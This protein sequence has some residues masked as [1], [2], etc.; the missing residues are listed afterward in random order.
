[1]VSHA[2]HPSIWEMETGGSEVQGYPSLHK[3]VEGKP[4]MHG[5]GLSLFCFVFFSLSKIAY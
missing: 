3:E 5:I 2:Y 4:G 1:M